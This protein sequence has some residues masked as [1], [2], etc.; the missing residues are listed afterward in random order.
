MDD[1]VVHDLKEEILYL[2][3]LLD[4]NG[5]KYDFEAYCLEKDARKAESPMILTGSPAKL[6]VQPEK[7]AI[8]REIAFCSP[9]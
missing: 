1:V 8:G 9:D 2:H 5:I 6:C 3:S 4:A 7:S